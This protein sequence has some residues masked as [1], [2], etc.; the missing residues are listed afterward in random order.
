[1]AEWIPTSQ[2]LPPAQWLRDDSERVLVWLGGPMVIVG[3]YDH[4][5]NQ[6]YSDEHV[7][8]TCGVT[9]WTPLP[10]PP[11]ERDLP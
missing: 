3:F 5:L 1:M 9:H 2:Q 10:L 6:W 8:I 4:E 11:K 7:E